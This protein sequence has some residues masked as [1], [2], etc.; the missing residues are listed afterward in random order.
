MEVEIGRGKKGRRAYGFDDIAIVPVAAHPRP[1][2]RRH[3]LDARARTGS[4]C[5]CSRPRWTASSARRPRPRSA[6]SA[7]SRCST[8]R[9]SGR[10]YE[11]AEEQLERD[12]RGAAA[13]RRRSIMQE[14]YSE[15]VKPELIA[16]RVEEIK[17]EGVVAAGSLTPQRVRR[18]LRARAR[19]RPRHPRH[20]GHRDL[21]RARLVEVRA[22]EPEGVHRRGAGA[23]HRRRLRLVLDR[24]APDAHR[25]GRRPRRGRPGRR[26]HDPRRARASASRRRPRSPTSR[27]PAPSTCS[28]PASTA[29]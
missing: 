4:S 15:P 8:S 6:G 10:R 14:I 3:H 16:Q 17:A 2:R 29:T 24:P 12:R 21:R 9:G 22:A 13:S 26:L 20:P 11:D 28:R 7:G 25:R 18:A 5:R 19:G 1:R 27:R 23:V